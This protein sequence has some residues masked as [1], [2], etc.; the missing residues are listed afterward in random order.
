MTEKIVPVKK[1]EVKIWLSF[2]SQVCSSDMDY[3]QEAF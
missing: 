3:L 1:D 2:A